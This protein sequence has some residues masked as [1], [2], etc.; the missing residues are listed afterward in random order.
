MP[1]QLANFPF[2]ILR[3]DENGTASDTAAT[4]LKEVP[5]A[6]LT[7]LFIFSHGWNNDEATAM[8]LYTGFFEQVR[9]LVD[10]SAIN[11]RPGA[12]IGVAG[13]DLAGDSFSWRCTRASKQRRRREPDNRRW[14]TDPGIGA[15]EDL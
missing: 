8:V 3:F 7:D 6:N 2:W 10:D 12:V 1:G 9:K 5:D 15:A 13:C 11:K 14:L 4:F